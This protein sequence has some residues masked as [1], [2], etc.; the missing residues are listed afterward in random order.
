MTTLNRTLACALVLACTVSVCHATIIE[1][2]VTPLPGDRLRY[3]YAVTND[4][5]PGPIIE[6]RIWFDADLFEDLLVE[7]REPLASDWDDALAL[8]DGIAPGERAI[9]FDISFYWP[10]GRWPRPRI[11]PF[12]VLDPV[13]FEIIDSGQTVVPEPGTLVLLGAAVVGLAARRR[14]AIALLKASS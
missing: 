10:D 14:A 2:H 11:Q 13:T 9:P 5:L 4:T 8:G 1:Y 7:T 12:D 3:S 6:F